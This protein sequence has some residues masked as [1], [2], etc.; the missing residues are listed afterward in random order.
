MITHLQDCMTNTP[1]NFSSWL[2]L[3]T[4]LAIIPSFRDA[5]TLEVAKS[6]IGVLEF[7]KPKWRS[8][9]VFE[10]PRELLNVCVQACSIRRIEWLHHSALKCVIAIAMGVIRRSNDAGC[11][12][13]KAEVE[14]GCV[15]LKSLS[16]NE[17]ASRH[18]IPCFT[19]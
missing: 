7:L 18:Q 9:A 8:S 16:C 15:N 17:Y 2:A 4:Y 19:E 1:E 3:Y 6:M 10:V 11:D 5:D 13:V 12:R 14:S